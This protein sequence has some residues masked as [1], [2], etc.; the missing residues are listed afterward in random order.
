MKDAATTRDESFTD[1][2]VKHAP[3]EGWTEEQQ[4]FL[5]QALEVGSFPPAPFESPPNLTGR[6]GGKTRVTP[7]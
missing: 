1:V 3:A 4:T 7:R 5:V 2:S 6:Q